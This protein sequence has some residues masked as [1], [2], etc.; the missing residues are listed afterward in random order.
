MSGILFNVGLRDAAFLFS[1]LK[2]ILKSPFRV[3]KNHES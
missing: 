3:N 2:F 1:S